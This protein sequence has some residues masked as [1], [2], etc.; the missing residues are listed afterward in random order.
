MRAILFL[1]ALL[2]I[3]GADADAAEPR[4]DASLR[5]AMSSL[6]PLTPTP[7]PALEGRVT[8]VTFFASWCPPCHAEFQHLNRLQARFADRDVAI[9]AINLFE[10]FGGLSS[11]AKLTRF[12]K[13]TAPTFPALRGTDATG[14]AFGDVT[15]IPTVFVFDR[16]GQP[17][18]RFVHAEGATKTHATFDELAAVVDSLL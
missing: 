2:A 9:V 16:T 11:P 15:R 10:D 5:A 8:V 14:V 6:E 13:R 17:L 1:L 7:L 4:L 18:W 3:H 12:L